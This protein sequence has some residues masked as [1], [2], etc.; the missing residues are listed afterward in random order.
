MIS[1]QVRKFA[2]IGL[3]VSASIAIVPLTIHFARPHI[4]KNRINQIRSEQLALQDHR[5]VNISIPRQPEQSN[6]QLPKSLQLQVPFTPQAP[7]ANWDELHNEACEEA[8]SIMAHAYFSGIKDLPP[9]YVEREIDKLTDWQNQT[10]GYHLSIDTQETVTM[11]SSFYKLKA[12]QVTISEPDIQLAL[13]Q[14]KLV[15]LPANGQLLK[16][17]NFKQPGPIYHML[18]ITGYENGVYITNDP[19]TRKG[20]NYQ[21]SFQTLYDAS[22]NWDHNKHAVDLTD[23]QIIIVSR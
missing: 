21:Y 19:G 18:V 17:P 7:T 23:K 6:S 20:F 15:L 4:F 16:N 13:N 1:K 3:I 12:E 10:F 22:G 14:N 8:S 5:P 11:I 2:A 9:D